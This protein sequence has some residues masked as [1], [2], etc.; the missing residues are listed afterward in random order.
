MSN[1]D[2]K[3]AEAAA[4]AEQAAAEKKAAE[5]K[6]AADAQAK[7][8]AEAKAA[9]EAEEAAKAEQEQRDAEA[10]VKAAAA[11]ARAEQAAQAEGPI[12]VVALRDGF[13]GIPVKFRKKGERFQVADDAELGRWMQRIDP[14]AAPDEAEV[15]SGSGKAEP[16]GEQSVI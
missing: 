10:K 11:K 14:N 5:Q 7:A 15:S 6:A 13:G 1:N 4:K 12:D 2:K 9:A 16:T 8:E 3:K